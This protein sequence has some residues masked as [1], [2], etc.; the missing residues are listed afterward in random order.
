[1][2]VQGVSVDQKSQILTGCPAVRYH[3]ERKV[4]SMT[5][6]DS[7]NDIK[8][9]LFGEKGTAFDSLSTAIL[10]EVKNDRVHLPPQYMMMKIT[11]YCNSDCVYC[12]HA[13]SRYQNEVKQ[14]I[15]LCRLLQIIDEA[16]A[17]G[18][19][20]IS[21]SGGEPLVR[22][23]IDRI[24]KRISEHHVVPVLLTN[25]YLLK[26]RARSLYENGLRYFIISLDSNDPDQ[27]QAQRGLDLDPVL[28]GMEAVREI[29]LQDDSVKLHITPVITAKNLTQ[30]PDM[31]E[32][33]SERGI[34]LQFS[35]YHRFVYHMKDELAEFNRDEVDTVID[36]LIR[37]KKEGYRIANSTAF[38]EHFR[39]FMKEGKVVPDKYECLAGFSTIYVDTYEN[40]LPC[41]S[42]GLGVVDHLS[43][44]SLSDIW[45]GETYAKMRRKMVKCQCPGCW[46]LCTGELTM[47]I[48]GQ[49]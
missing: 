5:I 11:N 40:V 28:E 17:L 25:G 7:V 22:P 2:L 1:M 45:Y 26:Q 32:Y 16:A 14:E 31:V 21:I 12:N 36:R 47:L 37:M 4:D 8:E 42:G 27:Y 13:K 39:S 35:P 34:S 49:E 3:E 33:Y 48:T 24:V 18:V 46:L 6:Y 23:D 43:N 29:M 15:P 44:Q 9:M 41:W 20:A 10:D 30:M 19:K 38:L